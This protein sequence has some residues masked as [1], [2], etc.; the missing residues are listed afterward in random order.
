MSLLVGGNGGVAILL[1]EYKA[2][3]IANCADCGASSEK[4]EWEKVVHQTSRTLT[5]PVVWYRPPIA[6]PPAAAAESLA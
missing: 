5:V 1:A 4:E 3:R 6:T 2:S